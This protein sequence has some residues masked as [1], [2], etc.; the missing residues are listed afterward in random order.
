VCAGDG[1]APAQVLDLLTRLVDKSLVQ[2][3]A[4]AGQARYRL[5]EP[6]RQY[7]QP[8]LEVSGEDAA[9]RRR[10]AEHYL[11]LAERAEPLLRGHEQA[12]W[13]ERLER[14]HDN[15]RAALGGAIRRHESDIA[16][17]L[18]AAAGEFWFL[19]GHL[20]E[21]RHWLEAALA[22]GDPT[23]QAGMKVLR[24]AATLLIA[25]GELKRAEALAQQSLALS[26]RLGDPHGEAR[27]L[28]ALAWA[29]NEQGDHRA[30]RAFAEQGLETVRPVGGRW[31]LASAFQTAG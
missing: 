18:A 4:V 9:I 17:R 10:H 3:Q 14:E 28:L 29:A 15:L 7:A 19:H 11:A 27:A 12:A 22:L 1:I 13:F 24:R 5:L 16:L 26:R 25:A 6:L 23:G 8:H 2:A 21:G 20:R 31:V 30:A